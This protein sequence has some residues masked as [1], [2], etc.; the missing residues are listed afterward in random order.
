MYMRSGS[1]CIYMQV[2]KKYVDTTATIHTFF[3]NECMTLI[4]FC[5]LR[6]VFI[7]S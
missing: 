1:Y 6:I 2:I 7:K 3:V 4:F 5:Y